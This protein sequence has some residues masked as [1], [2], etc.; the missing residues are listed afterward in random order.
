MASSEFNNNQ[1]LF[2]ILVPAYN[3]ERTLA[4]ALDS[5]MAQTMGCW[6]CI[7]V[8]DGSTDHTGEIAS[9]Y[10]LRDSRFVSV[11]QANAGTASALNKAASLATGRY[12]TQLG[13]DDEILPQY[14]EATAD[15]IKTY[16]GHSIFA[17][18]AWHINLEGKQTP[19]HLEDD[20]KQVKKISLAELIMK[21]CIYGTAAICREMFES[22]GGFSVDS[23][24]EDY[25]FW[26]RAL[27]TGAQ[28][29]YQPVFLARFYERVGQKTASPLI[30][31]EADLSAIL[32]LFDS[33][34]LTSDEKERALMRIARLEHDIKIRK[35]LYS[36]FG[37]Q[38][39][40][41]VITTT[42]KLRS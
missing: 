30:A 34:D 11:K 15:L 27:A 23:Y 28:H 1:V 24:S 3:A 18:N 39:T 38:L 16:L 22:L 32:N 9:K 19:F 35:T 20:F 40:E 5:V 41:S 25:D 13:A 4:R 21:P 37:K 14:C 6:E 29:V 7:I 8:D 36:F 17:S 26:L 31:R 2:S 42:R 10:V 12:L 33:C